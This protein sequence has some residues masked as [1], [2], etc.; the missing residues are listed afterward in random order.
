MNSNVRE[1]LRL[2][3]DHKKCSDYYKM[4]RKLTKLL[5]RMKKSHD[6][7]DYNDCIVAAKLVIDNDKNSQVFIQKSQSYICSCN[8]KA[9]N[10]RE[11][12]DSCSDLL[13]IN[14]NDAEALYN[15]AQAHITEE[16]LDD[17]KLNLIF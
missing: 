17:G 4:L 9:K 16:N 2:D 13:R 6:D 3:P 15:R 11:A 12:I 1:C 10:T 5:E 14:P 7:R 8:S